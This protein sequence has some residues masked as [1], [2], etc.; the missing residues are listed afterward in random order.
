MNPNQQFRGR[1]VGGPQTQRPGR[2]LEIE[3]KLFTSSEQTVPIRLLKGQDRVGGIHI[4][5]V[6]NITK[7]ESDD[8]GGK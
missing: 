5:P 6:F 7:I 4:F 8:A 1:V 3:Q 2:K